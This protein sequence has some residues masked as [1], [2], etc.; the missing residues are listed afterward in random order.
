MTVFR[1]RAAVITGGITG[2]AGAATASALVGPRDGG[3]CAPR[4]APTEDN[5][6][7]GLRSGVPKNVPLQG[8]LLLG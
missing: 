2:C 5:K 8:H 4:L 6:T 3:G 1:D 7:L